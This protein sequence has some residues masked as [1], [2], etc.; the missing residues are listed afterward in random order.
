MTIGPSELKNEIINALNTVKH[1]VSSRH[2]NSDQ[3]I[4]PYSRAIISLQKFPS[5]SFHSLYDLPK[6]SGIG[7]HILNSLI[8]HFK[9]KG[10]LHRVVNG[11]TEEYL[12]ENQRRGPNPPQI[13]NKILTGNKTK[14]KPV[15]EPAVKKKKVAAKKH[16]IPKRRSGSYAIILALLECYFTYSNSMVKD[17]II[18]YATVY[19]DSGFLT[20]SS[21]AEFYSAW[22]S[23][24]TLLN[25]NLVEILNGKSKPS[26]FGL[27]TEGLVLA[28][29]LK[30]INN[31]LFD[32]T[33]SD[34]EI[35]WREKWND[36]YRDKIDEENLDVNNELFFSVS[37]LSFAT[38]SQTY[39]TPRK[40]NT[41]NEINR[42]SENENN[43]IISLKATDSKNLKDLLETDNVQRMNTS[44]SSN[45]SI[46]ASFNKSFLLQE[47]D[48]HRRLTSLLSGSVNEDSASKRNG[49]FTPHLDH[50]NSKQIE[51]AKYN[52][53]I[54]Q[55]WNW[56]DYDI[57]L[58]IDNR[59]I[60]GTDDRNFFMQELQKKGIKCEVRQ[61]NIGDFIWI[62]RHKTTKRE[63]FLN[64]IIERKRID[65][66]CS[67][68]KDGRFYEQ[69]DRLKKIGYKWCF[70]LVEESIVNSRL[71]NMAEAIK[72]S[73]F[74][75]SLDSGFILHRCKNASDTV[76][77]LI[78]IHN[79]ISQR[80]V[81]V[82][83][84]IIMIEKSDFNDQQE[85]HD[86]LVV[87]RKE[88]EKK[89]TLDGTAIDS[90]YKSQKLYECCHNF[91]NFQSVMGKSS[92]LTAN[93]LYLRMLL[94]IKGCSLEKAF[95]VVS[96]YPTFP[97]LM[98]G[99]KLCKTKK[100]SQLFL[101]DK[102]DMY[103]TQKKIGKSLSEKFHET[104]G[105]HTF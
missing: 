54:Y 34:F 30:K 100:E 99:Y 35:H 85:L 56:N 90:K 25:K 83:K 15:K 71:M 37:S 78:L 49:S 22:T 44:I 21:T 72:T 40:T 73:F 26:R 53:I 63:V 74:E 4:I 69:K 79:L 42:H 86:T 70:Y 33:G 45:N 38:G 68:I 58:L 98:N 48:T 11:K 91:S 9:D 57:I 47:T 32:R 43:F 95:S 6:V 67:S 103:P 10:D 18:E 28:A 8:K 81:K 20:N 84:N 39:E 55:V 14:P 82:K 5:D 96:Q 7:N 60:R 24:K 76:A 59:E 92:F 29:T 77:Y 75:T 41:D 23:M 89:V 65:D 16:Y 52:N 46:N 105:K 1:E 12:K 101:Y 62:G 50:D 13:D 94:S 93:E 19:C 2:K 64:S 97:D 66:L 3:Y 27:T 102:F 80:L 31:I 17:Q 51:T 61:L 36:L 87:F 104:F 88:F